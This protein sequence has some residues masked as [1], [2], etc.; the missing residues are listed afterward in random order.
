MK[1]SWRSEWSERRSARK[2]RGG[3]S[4]DQVT[5]HV[6]YPPW[7][8]PNQHRKARYGVGAKGRAMR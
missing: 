2:Q 6:A 7:N 1:L 3:A 5:Y 8:R 4:G